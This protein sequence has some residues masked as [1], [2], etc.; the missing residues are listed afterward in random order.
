[1]RK[2]PWVARRWLRKAPVGANEA[3]LVGG[4]MAQRHRARLDQP[5]DG[6]GVALS[7]VGREARAVG[8]RQP[9]EVD[10]V[11]EREGDAMERSPIHS[12]SEVRIDLRGK[13]AGTRVQFPEGAHDSVERRDPRQM[14]VEQPLGGQSA[15]SERRAGLGDGRDRLGGHDAA[16]T[17]SAARARKR[18]VARTDATS[19]SRRTIRRAARLARRSASVT[20]STL[21]ARR[22]VAPASPA[23]SAPVRRRRAIRRRPAH[24]GCGGASSPSPEAAC[25]KARPAPAG[26]RSPD[27]APR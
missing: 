20:P 7:R 5:R 16:R 12:R 1:M 8:R 15:V 25:P 26:C 3:P 27:G 18:A 24:R 21:K 11:L 9:F 14:Q 17:R 23:P 10:H 13:R 19:S 6:R 2:V 4:D 22:P